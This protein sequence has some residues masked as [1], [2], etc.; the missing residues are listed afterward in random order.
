MQMLY[1]I[2]V[3]SAPDT[4]ILPDHRIHTVMTQHEEEDVGRQNSRR[5]LLLLDLTQFVF[6]KSILPCVVNS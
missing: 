5:E 3:G 4:R 1:A 6:L 2:E